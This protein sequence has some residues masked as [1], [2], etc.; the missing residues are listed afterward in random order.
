MRPA[1]K[2][3]RP[4]LD[5]EAH[6]LGHQDRVARAG[7]RRCSSGRRRSR[8]PSPRA[9]S[10]AV[11]TPA[12][13]ITGTRLCS[14]MIRRLYG[15]AD[16]EAGADR[17]RERHHRRAA[18]LLEALAGDRIVGDVGQHHEALAAPARAAA[19]I[20]AAHVG[21]ERLL[22]A[23]HLELHER[24]RRPPRA[25]GGAAPDDLLGGVAAGRVREDGERDR[26]AADRSSDSRGPD[27]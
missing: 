15:I 5:A 19:S 16:A 22:V 6:R 21:E 4:G 25:R 1:R 13:T 24:C 17:R 20:V 23:D 11:P 2:A 26:A 9:A 14:R 8:A 12:S 3:S 27:R 18:E 10:E 7:D